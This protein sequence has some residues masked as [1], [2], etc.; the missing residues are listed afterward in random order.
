VFSSSCN[1]IPE[2]PGDPPQTRLGQWQYHQNRNQNPYSRGYTNPPPPLYYTKGYQGP[3]TYQQEGRFIPPPYGQYIMGWEGPNPPQEDCILNKAMDVNDTPT[4]NPH[5]MAP[6]LRRR[7][8]NHQGPQQ[9]CNDYK[10]T[11]HSQGG[12][13]TSI[14]GKDKATTEA[15]N[16]WEA[17]EQTDQLTELLDRLSVA[18]INQSIMDFLEREELTSLVVHQLLDHIDCLQADLVCEKKA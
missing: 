5:R 8:P 15:I 2:W 11:T 12:G 13:C 6:L 14:K 17:R 4:S 10:T 1:D 9:E 16:H 7:S 18:D 3:N